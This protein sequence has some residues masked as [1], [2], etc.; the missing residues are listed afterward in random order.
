MS[1]CYY[2]ILGISRCAN[3]EE[4]R[5][6][7]RK[8]ALKF[9]PDKNKDTDAEERFKEIA[10]AY[11]VLGNSCKRKV[12]DKYGEQGLKHGGNSG[13][14][15]TFN[16]P[17]ETFASFFG[18]QDPFANWDDMFMDFDDTF[19]DVFSR[20]TSSHFPGF[21]GCHRSRTTPNF[22][23]RSRRGCRSKQLP[24]DPPV[25]H[26]L[27]VSLEEVATG[28]TKR[29]RITRKRLSPCGLASRTENK[30][31]VVE[32]KR[33]WKEGTKI[34]F[35]KEGDEKANTIPADVIFIVKDIPHSIFQRDGSDIIYQKTLTLKEALVGCELQIPTLDARRT[36]TIPCYDVIKPNSEKRI[37]G[38]GLPIPKQLSQ[39]GDLVVQFTVN[40]PAFLNASQKSA[41]SHILP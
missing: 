31:L 27:R 35:A 20:T 41:L 13:C 16:D 40:F 10:E 39:R 1:R 4:I 30:I 19:Q 28:C 32:I 37:Q 5:R 34:T 7:Y 2:E 22:F 12:Y 33:G 25:I 29:M 26:D 23:C 11:E 6:A 14:S 38:E 24:Q 15:Y 3:D 8:M 21:G 9:H 18:G 17:R 36:L